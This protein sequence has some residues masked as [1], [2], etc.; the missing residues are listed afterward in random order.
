MLFRL[1]QLLS[2]RK[3]QE[4][5][6]FLDRATGDAKEV[7]A[8]GLREPPIAFGDV[9]GDGKGGAVQLIGK[10][11]VA[12]RQTVRERADCIRE[13]NCLLLNMKFL[14]SEGH[15]RASRQECRE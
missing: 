6:A 14:K 8:V 1:E 11:K 13:S 2:C 4:R 7:A 10:K 9:C 12:P 15:L 3:F 5:H